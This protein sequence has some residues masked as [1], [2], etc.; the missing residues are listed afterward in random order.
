M[1]ERRVDSSGSGH[2][3]WRVLTSWYNE[4]SGSLKCGE[5]IDWVRNC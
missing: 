4:L 1:T 3:K 5:F 2:D